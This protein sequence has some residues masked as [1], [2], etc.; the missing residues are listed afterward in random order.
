M[1]SI[2]MD[3]PSKVRHIKCFCV[4]APWKRCAETF[5]SE[6]DVVIN[7]APEDSSH[8]ALGDGMLTAVSQ[9]NCLKIIEALDLDQGDYYFL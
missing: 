2:G 8:M 6:M 9:Q 5:Y 1:I 7:L 3:K 4:T